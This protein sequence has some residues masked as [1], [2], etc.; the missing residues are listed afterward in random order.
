MDKQDLLTARGFRSTIMH[1]SSGEIE[2][3]YAPFRESFEKIKFIWVFKD[4]PASTTWCIA[5]GHYSLGKATTLD[6]LD[7]ILAAN[8]LSRFT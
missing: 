2:A 1:G 3:V 7:Q 6:E 4:S 8:N 5:M